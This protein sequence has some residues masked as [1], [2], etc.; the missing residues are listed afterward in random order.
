MTAFTETTAP[1]EVVQTW[2]SGPH[3]LYVGGAWSD[4]ESGATFETVNP[5][6]GE[7]L[8]HVA[9]AGTGDVD[10]AVAA[11]AAAFHDER[12]QWRRMSGSDRGKLL[13]RLADLV[14]AHADE[15]AMLET[16]D[17]GKPLAT[18]RSVDLEHTID[19][20]RYFAGWATKITG[21]TIPLTVPSAQGGRFFAYTE[22]EPVGVVAA[23]IP[24]NFPLLHIAFKVGPALAAGCTVILKPAEQTPLTALRFAELVAE[25]GFPGGVF[26]VLTGFGHVAG[27]ALASHRAVD[28]ITFTGSTPV[29]KAVARAAA[30]SNLKRVSLELGGKSPNIIFADADM[31]VAISG[32]ADAIFF[33]SGQV[34]CAGT[35]LYVEDSVFDRVI[36]GLSDLARALTVGDGLNPASNI[37]PL[38]SA[39]QLEQVDAMTAEGVSRGAEAVT[40]GRRIRGSGYFYE[41]T[42]L[43]NTRPEMAVVRE[44]IFGP[45]VVATPFRNPDEIEPAAND[46]VFGLAAGLWTRDI[47]KAH[48]I[49]PRLNAGTVWINCWNV[50]D[51]ALPFGG[52]RESG[53]GREMGEEAVH[54]YTELKAVCLRY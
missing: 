18:A 30:D 37:G 48:A 46:T 51:A 28:K 26:N 49:A 31:D 15:L 34:C 35:R 25:A 2:L 23:I 10:R 40:G 5:A 24:W 8:A 16:L 21:S 20:Y 7:P 53:W 47:S 13:W 45:V 14:E 33:N 52:Y 3:R 22:R 19:M 50:F 27:A 29:G 1:S 12:S 39:T 36:A 54:A 6:T 42:I 43:V 17:N 41:P 4:A 11:A 44:E 32:A 9:E 38:I